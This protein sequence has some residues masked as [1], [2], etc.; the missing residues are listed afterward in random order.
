MEVGVEFLHERRNVKTRQTQLF[1]LN[2]LRNTQVVLQAVFRNDIPV[3]Q[4]IVMMQT[5]DIPFGNRVKTDH[6]KHI[7][8]KDQILQQMKIIAKIQIITDQLFPISIPESAQI[9]NP[10]S[11][12]VGIL[13]K[14]CFINR[15]GIRQGLSPARRRA[16]A[17]CTI[18][19]AIY[20]SLQFTVF[21]HPHQRCIFHTAEEFRNLILHF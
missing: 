5:V 3:Q 10:F 18:L 2:S 19:E 1:P 12:I 7:V 13:Q 14:M 15:S 6:F 4:F 20:I 11:F 8:T 21:H 16:S 9:M 17:K